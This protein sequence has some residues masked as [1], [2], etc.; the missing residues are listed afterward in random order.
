[1]LVPLRIAPLSVCD[2]EAPTDIYSLVKAIDVCSATGQSGFPATGSDIYAWVPGGDVTCGG[3]T[4]MLLSQSFS[5]STVC[6]GQ[7]S[8]NETMSLTNC[9]MCNNICKGRCIDNCITAGLPFQHGAEIVEKFCKSPTDVC[10]SGFI[11]T[12]R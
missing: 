6:T 11:F 5:P 9:D 1:M 10:I 2:L 8:V 4:G 12:V 3:F 7:M